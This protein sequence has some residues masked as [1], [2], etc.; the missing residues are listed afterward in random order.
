M[1]F[2]IE[3]FIHGY[4]RY[5]L[6]KDDSWK[7]IKYSPKEEPSSN[8]VVVAE[9]YEAG[10]LI[11]KLPKTITIKGKKYPVNP[12]SFSLGDPTVY[13]QPTVYRITKPHQLTEAEVCSAIATGNDDINNTL[14]VDLE[15]R[16]RL[17]KFNPAIVTSNFSGIAVRNE[18]FCAGNEYVGQEAARDKSHV[19][20]QYETL[21]DG[22]I[23]HLSTGKVNIFQDLSP[24][25]S[26][27]KMLVDLTG[28]TN[29]LK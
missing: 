13:V 3:A 5:R 17:R 7:D 11:G 18:T 24:S 27:E 1:K 22:W 2:L 25:E 29:H 15:G 23:T 8:D 16:V 21:L 6:Q 14:T 4:D 12:N 28:L 19:T 26:E 9:L 20:E 10:F